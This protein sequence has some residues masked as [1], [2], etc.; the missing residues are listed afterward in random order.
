[1]KLVLAR[2]GTRPFSCIVSYLNC[3]ISHPLPHTEGH[4]HVA[5]VQDLAGH[6][7]HASL[8][9]LSHLHPQREQ[10]RQSIMGIS[11][12]CS[13]SQSLSQY[14]RS[15]PHIHALSS[16][17]PLSPPNTSPRCSFTSPPSPHFREPLKDIDPRPTHPPLHIRRVPH[18]RPHAT[19]QDFPRRP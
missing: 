3:V 17:A 18:L 2:L 19:I 16:Q 1:M 11:D 10:R 13:P 4:Q 14:P 6:P 7:D 5:N 8:A 9:C 12:Q 15:R